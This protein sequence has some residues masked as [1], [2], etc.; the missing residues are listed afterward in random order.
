MH[1]VCTSNRQE[2]SV[3]QYVAH[4]VALPLFLSLSMNGNIGLASWGN[5][6]EPFKINRVPA[7]VQRFLGST[8]TQVRSPAQNS[9]L[10]IHC[11]HRSQ[12]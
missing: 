10:R 9:G 4:V 8:G 1:I 3:I 5:Q 2:A 6:V 11:C 7:V 12:L